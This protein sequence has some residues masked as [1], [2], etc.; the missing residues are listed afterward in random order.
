[1]GTPVR[2][3]AEK[4][5]CAKCKGEKNHNIIQTYAENS[6]DPD[7]IRWKMEYH[8]IQ[9]SGCD[10][11]AFA[12]QYGDE[13]M[14]EYEN[15]ER[16]WVDNFTVY[17]NEPN[18]QEI[19]SRLLEKYRLEAKD[20]TYAP[21]EIVNLYYQILESYHMNHMIL[22]T[23]GLRTLIEVVCS[24]RGINKG[25]LYDAG[26]NKIKDKKGN[27]IITESLGGRIFGLFEEGHI[28]FTQALILQKIKDIGNGA[29]HEIKVPSIS[30]LKDAIHVVEDIINNIYEIPNHRLLK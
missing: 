9:C 7:E 18:K 16:I 21:I 6:T 14:W 24:Q 11:V 26:K 30:T 2:R 29:I 17:P 20:F 23:S 8:I 12:K 5:Y 10:E 22:C 25:Y 28:V 19:G 4:V 15:G 27:E 13:D 3:L 1:M